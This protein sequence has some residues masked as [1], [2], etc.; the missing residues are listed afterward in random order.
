MQYQCKEGYGIIQVMEHRSPG[1]RFGQSYEYCAMGNGAGKLQQPHKGA[2]GCSTGE[3]VWET[4]LGLVNDLDLP[5]EV[6][7]L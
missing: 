5:A 4:R 1:K 6:I 7:Q 2:T 3:Q